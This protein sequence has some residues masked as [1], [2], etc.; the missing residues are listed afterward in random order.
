MDNLVFTFDMLFASG[1]AIILYAF[2][3]EID[4][5]SYQR[6]LLHTVEHVGNPLQLK[7]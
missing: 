7:K 4:L 1:A 6:R 5:A 2:F 3:C